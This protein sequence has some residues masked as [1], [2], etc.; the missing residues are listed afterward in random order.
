MHYVEYHLLMAPRCFQANLDPARPIDRTF[1]VVRANKFIFYS[2]LVFLA[3]VVFVCTFD[4]S[5]MLSM[6][7]G[8]PQTNRDGQSTSLLFF[9]LFDGLFVF[10]YFLESFIWR[11]SEPYYRKT[12]APLY[13]GPRPPAAPTPQPTTTGPIAAVST[14][15]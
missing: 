7:E 14:P 10:H 6:I 1:A 15:T 5:A 12:L 3:F 13:F 9:A 2:L 11:F 8:A 4:F